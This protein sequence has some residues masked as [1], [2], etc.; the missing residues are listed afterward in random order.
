MSTVWGNTGGCAN[1]YRCDLDV[2]LMTMFSSLYDTIMDRAMNA[3]SNVNNVV[4]GLNDT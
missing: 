3:L 2:Y 4:Y 1:Q